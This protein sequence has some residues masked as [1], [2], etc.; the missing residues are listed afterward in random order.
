VR[1]TIIEN[2]ILNS[3]FREPNRHFRFSEEGITNEIV[4]ARRASAYFVPIPPPKKKGKQ[5]QFETQWTQDRI[6]PNDQVNRIRERVKHWREG[7]FQGVTQITGKLLQ[8]WIDPDRENKLFFCQVEALETLICLT[9][10]A[11]KVGDHGIENWLRDG[12][13]SSNPGLNRVAM[14]MATGTGKTVVMA[15]LIAWHALNKIADPR[16]RRFS[17]TFLVVTPGIT[18]RDRLRV[19]LPNDAEN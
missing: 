11:K 8:H 3:P 7:E 12:N 9:E 10:S 14:K 19:L 16:D 5:L 15:M 13:E 6:Q 18:I 1:D 17:D 4:E 2:P